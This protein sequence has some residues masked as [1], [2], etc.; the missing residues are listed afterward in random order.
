MDAGDLHTEREE[1]APGKKAVRAGGPKLCH[2][3]EGTEEGHWFCH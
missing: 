2:D 3:Q 1:E